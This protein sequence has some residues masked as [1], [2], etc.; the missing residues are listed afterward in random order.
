MRGN[1]MKIEM[2]IV[3]YKLLSYYEEMIYYCLVS[4]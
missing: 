2:K 3:V 4:V 1:L